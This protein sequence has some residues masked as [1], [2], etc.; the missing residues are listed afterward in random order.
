MDTLQKALRLSLLAIFLTLLIGISNLPHKPVLWAFVALFVA[1]RAAEIFH[2]AAEALAEWHRSSAHPRWLAWL[3]GLT[4]VTNIALPIL[5]HRYRGEVFWASPLPVDTWW[6][7]L[8]LLGLLA[9]AVLR[10]QT[11]SNVP[12]PQKPAPSKTAS[13]RRRNSEE[14]AEIQKY[15]NNYLSLLHQQFSRAAAV[16][17]IGTAVLFTSLWGLLALAII[18]LPTMLYRRQAE[19]HAVPS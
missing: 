13:K 6:S 2:P 5:D 14:E 16:S 3:S 1:A 11:F 9:G 15:D 12:K 8:G 19:E 4:F 17:Y 10:W 18:V 7:W